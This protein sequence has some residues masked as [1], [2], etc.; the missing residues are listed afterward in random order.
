MAQKQTKQIHK[1]KN[2]N[3]Q[4]Q[5]HHLMAQKQTKTTDANTSIARCFLFSVVFLV[6]VKDRKKARGIVTKNP[7]L[8]I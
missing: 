4:I 5:K 7:K 2:T 6:G 3:T 1:Y 8:K